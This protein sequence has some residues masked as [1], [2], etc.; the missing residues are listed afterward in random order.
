ME[1]FEFINGSGHPLPQPCPRHLSAVLPSDGSPSF[2]WHGAE[3][4]AY[5]AQHPQ[6]SDEQIVKYLEDSGQGTVLTAITIKK[7]LGVF[8]RVTECAE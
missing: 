5:R 7:T 2:K 8:E 6:Q 4:G 3:L 1:A